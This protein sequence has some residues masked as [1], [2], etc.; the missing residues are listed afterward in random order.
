MGIFQRRILQIGFNS[1]VGLLLLSPA[2]ARPAEW[3]LQQAPAGR[4]NAVSF[5][6][7][8]HGIIGMTA[9]GTSFI[10]T[11]DGGTNWLPVQALNQYPA[12]IDWVDS[13]V[14]VAAGS[15]GPA[16]IL[17]TIDGGL[18]WDSLYGGGEVLYGVSA[19]SRKTI[20]AVGSAIVL[21][22]DGGESWLHPGYGL[23][24]PLS[25][26][27]FA[28]SSI[29]V[30]VSD[31]GFII[32]TTDGGMNWASEGR[33][34]DYAVNIYSTPVNRIFLSS[35]TGYAA[36][37]HRVLKTTD[38]GLTWN[39]LSVSV[40]SGGYV[41][42]FFPNGSTG[43]LLSRTSTVLTTDGGLTWN[44]AILPDLAG[45]WIAVHTTADGSVTAGCDNGI[46]VRTPD[47]RWPPVP[48][49][50]GYPADGNS[51]VPLQVIDSLPFATMLRVRQY[52]DRPFFRYRMQVS[53]DSLFTSIIDSELT[54]D[55][56]VNTMI[57]G[58]LMPSTTYSWRARAER[59]RWVGPWS[60]P[61]RFS[62]A[63]FPQVTLMQIQQVSPDSL[64]S[65]DALQLNGLSFQRSPLYNQQ[66]LFTA[67]STVPPGVLYPDS[68]VVT[69]TGNIN[70][71]W[72]SIVVYP[73]D[74]ADSLF[75]GVRRGD[76]LL[77]AGL[78]GESEGNTTV[79]CTGM[80]RLYGMP[81]DFSPLPVSV[82]DFMRDGRISF[83][84]GEQFEGS[85]VVFRDLT[86]SAWK[87][88]GEFTL[89]DGLGQHID[90]KSASAW[91]TIRPEYRDSLSTYSLP[92]IGAHVDSLRG[93]LDGT[94]GFRIAPLYPG[95]FALAAP[96]R[97]LVSGEVFRD[98]D[99]NGLRDSGEPL[100]PG[101]RLD[102][103]LRGFPLS[104]VTTDSD[105]L[106]SVGY[107]DTG[108][109]LMWAEIQPGWV[110]TT[111]ATNPIDL[112]VHA[113]D[114]INNLSIGMY[115][116]SA[117]LTGMIYDDDNR[118]GIQDPGEG[119]IPNWPVEVTS[120]SGVRGGHSD[121]LGIY[122]ITVPE[123]GTAGITIA[124]GAGWMRT[125][126][127]ADTVYV[128][129]TCPQYVYRQNFG[130]A[131]LWNS[132]GGS[133]YL[134]VNESGMY[135]STD[136]SLPG[137]TVRLVRG[138]VLDSTSTDAEGRYSFPRISSEDCV[139]S[140][141]AANSM[142]QIFPQLQQP[143][144]MQI[145]GYDLHYRSV[146]F[147]F[148]PLPERIKTTLTVHE[149]GTTTNQMLW[150]GIRPGASR[151][152]WGL[153]PQAGHVDFSEGEFE[154]PTAPAGS[155]DARFIAP[156]DVERPIY[157]NG[158][159][160]DIRGYSTPVQSDTFRLLVFAGT[161]TGGRYPMTI[162]W[163]RDQIR[164]TY[165]GPVLLRA[166]GLGPTSMKDADSL[167]LQD[168]TI[169][170]LE[171]TTSSPDSS[172]LAVGPEA[173]QVPAKFALLQ[174]YPNPF[175]PMT[176]ISFVVGHSS[177]VTLK[178]YDVL[179]REVTTLVNES[180]PPGTYTVEWDSR[181]YGSGVYFC[182]FRAGAYRETRKILLLK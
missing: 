18:S 156:S 68:M 159:W 83:T 62:S 102:M 34:L 46:V 164:R 160:A 61:W 32:R 107:L 174:N 145:N 19:V 137:L 179:G 60:G 17:Q 173:A 121:P 141:E 24:S 163:S 114:T 124:R 53:A 82:E 108:R 56:G 140:I 43:V 158:S 147:A 26:I 67:L 170:V 65:A 142:E 14:A 64:A 113:G 168:S 165:N 110:V 10:R 37:A 149:T 11:T 45:T 152:I 15:Y 9:N 6:D 128:G 139:V 42:A 27:D 101:W 16:N 151:G 49:T 123:W 85:L 25:G 13:G 36:G 120:A 5:A 97:T 8:R 130:Y 44:A 122:T 134:D 39:D 95:D 169:H 181:D 74:A 148:H 79:A 63:P 3:T 117:V 50:P 54:P 73:L 172:L 116:T 155:F 119:G 90:M 12:W 178:V 129:L 38:R 166:G 153:D 136:R 180:R 125:S 144:F 92:P 93:L 31:D 86:V 182:R 70:A 176:T 150:C 118:N 135:D 77:L 167:I 52:L 98:C 143:Y 78:V 33:F 133:A 72:H 138:A 57:A 91:Y 111:P 28:D 22:R 115:G 109:C 96:G 132:I 175:N 58:G 2:G 59:F 30:A 23:Q 48:L 76:V 4:I 127:P 103:T 177:I 21:T 47:P 154:L 88:G 94:Q 41:N 157:G 100:L 1:G 105:G 35:D 171:M 146:D 112:V 89:I 106:F 81:A 104:P 55:F 75:T 99:Q 20:V 84:A 69:D 80:R 87:T 7:P 131:F 162:T 161:E 126:P 51:L 71:P 66:V 40:P 29:G